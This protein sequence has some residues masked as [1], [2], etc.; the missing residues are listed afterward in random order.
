MSSIL[1]ALKKLDEETRSQQGLGGIPKIEVDHMVT[2]HPQSTFRKVIFIIIPVLVLAVALWVMFNS[3]PQSSPERQAPPPQ[4][5]VQETAVQP[6]PHQPQA[7]KQMSAQRQVSSQIPVQQ[8]AEVSSS[9]ESNQK[10]PLPDGGTKTESNS[11]VT[12]Q[13]AKKEETK[14]MKPAAAERA[15]EPFKPQA[16]RSI[17]RDGRNNRVIQP[18]VQPS[19]AV[20]V[21]VQARPQLILEGILWSENVKRR[22]ALIND[23]YLK[24]GDTIKGVTI[25]RIEKKSVSL[26]FAEDTW[27]IRLKQ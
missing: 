11:Q 24:E 15:E 19:P 10:P 3:R 27:T 7:E 13:T 4:I 20:Q 14:A 8:A 12:V 25:V 17:S 6:E 18:S 21:P 23:K 22:V 16:N 26:K 1:R 9:T 5:P 2:R